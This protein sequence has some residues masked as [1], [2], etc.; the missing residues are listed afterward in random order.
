MWWSH[1]TNACVQH[2]VINDTGNQQYGAGVVSNG[3]CE[4]LKVSMG[5]RA[6]E[7]GKQTTQ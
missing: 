3:I 4:M 5:S 1:F 2:T 6:M 7:V